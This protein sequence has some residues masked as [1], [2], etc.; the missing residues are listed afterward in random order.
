MFANLGGGLTKASMWWNQGEGRREGGHARNL[1]SPVVRSSNG[2]GGQQAVGNGKDSGRRYGQVMPVLCQ[3]SQA[4]GKRRTSRSSYKGVGS[5]DEEVRKFDAGK[6]FAS[7]EVSKTPSVDRTAISGT[8][9]KPTT[10]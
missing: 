6:S 10:T 8:L 2:F 4:S 9:V 7:L 5:S 3:V 1:G